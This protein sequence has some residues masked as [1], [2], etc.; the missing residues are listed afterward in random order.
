[1][2]S[3]FSHKNNA[4]SNPPTPKRMRYSASF[5]LKVAKE[6]AESNNSIA[7]RNHG[8][9]ETLVRNWRKVTSELKDF[10]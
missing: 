5:K 2:I 1:M 9:N 4:M 8:I 10:I 7:A 6:A 3:K